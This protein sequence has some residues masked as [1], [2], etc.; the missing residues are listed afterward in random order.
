M[1]APARQPAD[2]IA[3]GKLA[4]LARTNADQTAQTTL[5]G[6]GA[7]EAD[8]TRHVK[9]TIDALWANLKPVLLQVESLERDWNELALGAAD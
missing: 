9:A 3:N 5:V 7:P 6:N 2:D 1:V 4:D 8:K